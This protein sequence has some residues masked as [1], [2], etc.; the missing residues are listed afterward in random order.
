MPLTGTSS[1]TIRLLNAPFWWLARTIIA[2][3]SSWS[4]SGMQMH[5]TQSGIGATGLKAPASAPSGS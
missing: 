1:S 3:R 5:E 2:R 4:A